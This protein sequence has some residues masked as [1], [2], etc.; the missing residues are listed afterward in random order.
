MCTEFRGARVVLNPGVFCVVPHDI[1]HRTMAET[2][3]EVLIFEPAQTPNTGNIVDDH[4]T[5]PNGVW[6]IETLSPY[7]IDCF[8]RHPYRLR[9]IMVRNRSTINAAADTRFV[10][11]DR[12]RHQQLVRGINKF[13]MSRCKI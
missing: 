13:R 10:I 11:V 3:A 4:F 7:W 6:D 2:E 5:A 1:E 8:Q 9:P 12:I